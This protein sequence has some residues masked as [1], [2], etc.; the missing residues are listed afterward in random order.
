M[1]KL[2]FIVA[3]LMATTLSF[4]QDLIITGT[5][6][7]P[8]TGGVPKGIE[9]Y[10]INNIADLSIYGV[11]SANNGDGSDGEEFTFPADAATAGDFIYL[12]SE[13]IEF[14]NFFGFAPNY[15]SGA[16]SINGDDAIELFMNG[17]VVD[18]FGDI[19]VDGTGEPWEY[20]DGWAYRVDGTGP[21]G[22]TFVLA[23][24]TFSGINAFD[25]QT[26]NGTS[27]TPFPVGAYTYI[28]S[29]DPMLTISYPSN[30]AVFNPEMTDLDVVFN[31]QNF[32]VANGTGDGYIK[33]TL[34]GG[35]VTSY[36]TIDPISLTSLSSGAHDFYMELVD[37]SGD[38]LVPAVNDQVNFEIATYTDVADLAGLRAGTLGEY[39]RVTGE[40]IGTFAHAYR[41]QKWVQDTTAGLLIDDNDGVIT[42]VYVEGDGVVNL[43]GKLGTFNDVIQLL[44]TADPG[45]PNSTGNII[46]PE[47]ITLSDLVSVRDLATY[48][49][50]LIQVLGVTITDY[51]DGGAGTADGT[52]QGGENYPIDDGTASSFLR[53]A[54]QDAN[55]VVN[56]DP[57]PTN[58]VDMVCLVG[59]YN[60]T[61]QVTPR[62]FWDFLG[63]DQQTTISGFSLYPNP[64][65][66]GVIHIAT[67]SNLSKDIQ[68]FDVLGKQVLAASISTSSLNIA[69]L[70]PGVYIIKVVEEGHFATRKLV[71]E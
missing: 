64:V 41:N 60:G 4:G 56:N 31:V 44:P 21:D 29:P 38:P 53:T 69:H 48:E 23:N 42:T 52:F 58:P 10:V 47:V 63:V 8:L 16:M 24:W 45:A 30:G 27:P 55:Y 51:D 65:K 57:L 1:K 71:V 9:I 6:D 36:Y 19:N 62:N 15:T 67:D 70:N 33:Y 50:E 25:D 13:D 17:G 68:I 46:V 26:T 59:G 18:I 2:Y 49:S 20:L 12:A 61:P 14:A 39:Y 54:F 11:G 37:N 40:V 7:G 5:F 34:D 43:R 35:S 66:N 28:A 3:F 32:V 22:S